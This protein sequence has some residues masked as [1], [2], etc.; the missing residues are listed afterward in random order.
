MRN[1]GTRAR[2]RSGASKV[3]WKGG[4][5]GAALGL[6]GAAVYALPGTFHGQ[7]QQG[8]QVAVT[9][10]TDGPAA[11]PGSVAA[12]LSRRLGARTAGSYV[13]RATG[14]IVTTVTN[15]ADART[16]RAAGGT[17]KMVSYSGADLTKATTALGN[18]VTTPGTGWAVDPAT[19]QVVVWADRS[20]GGA[21][22]TAVRAATARLGDMAR[23]ERISG[24]L[25]TLARGGDAIF[26]G[27]SRCSLGFNVRSGSQ[28][29]FLT[30]GHC[31]NIANAWFAD[32]AGRSRLGTTARS[33][34]PGNDFAIVRYDAGVAHPGTVSL[35]GGSTQDIT[36]AAN[37]VVGQSV[38]R[39]G[40]TTGVHSG[41]VTAVNATVNYPEG[42][43]R[44][45][46]RTTVCA[47]PGDSGGS[48]F[49]GNTALG[50]TSGGN[51]DCRTGGTTF[52]QPV[53]EPLSVF[54]VSVY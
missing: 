45:L 54:G 10:R 4:A 12:T 19:N 3:G 37:A 51:G 47:E 43:V 31:G 38:R 17:P 48:L 24:R 6:V 34:F 46:I 23:V 26:G 20:I 50:L 14:G 39:S 9:D 42:T 2:P 29:F 40:S 21:R 18:M 13:D 11:D 36:R 7:Q 22:L 15:A 25:T 44:G 28:F 52:F 16:V 30:A 33:S 53:T 8:R 32:S 35:G 41:R 49:A 5:I 27:G 1:K